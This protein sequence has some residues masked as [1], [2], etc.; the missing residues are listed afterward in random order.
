MKGATNKEIPRSIEKAKQVKIV[1]ADAGI[2][3]R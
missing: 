3:A 1:I 2:I